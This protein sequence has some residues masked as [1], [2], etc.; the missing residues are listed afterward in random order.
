MLDFEA[1]PVASSS[2]IHPVV[3]ELTGGRVLGSTGT[4][5]GSVNG[6]HPTLH[7][8]LKSMGRYMKSNLSEFKASS[9]LSMA[10]SFSCCS[11]CFWDEEIRLTIRLLDIELPVLEA[12]G[13]Q[14]KHLVSPSMSDITMSEVARVTRETRTAG[15]AIRRDVMS[16]TR[17]RR[18]TG[19]PKL[20]TTLFG[21]PSWSRNC[22]GFQKKDM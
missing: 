15:D 2:G 21:F 11:C 17:R 20:F 14:T 13:S 19:G 7:L 1:K 8:F 18:R 9:R 4:S 16:E 12:S 5:G 3:R 10:P 22:S 6:R